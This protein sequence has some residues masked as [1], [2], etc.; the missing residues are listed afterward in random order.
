MKQPWYELLPPLNQKRQI[1][2]ALPYLMGLKA[3][4]L[5]EANDNNLAEIAGH[6]LI[7]VYLPCDPKVIDDGR[8]AVKRLIKQWEQRVE[9]DP[10]DV[11][12][13]GQAVYEYHNQVQSINKVRLQ[14]AIKK[15]LKK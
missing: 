13:V 8:R 14:K 3:L 4:E 6:L 1:E 7:A 5:G 11:D 9:F 10:S 15:V 2:Y 12:L